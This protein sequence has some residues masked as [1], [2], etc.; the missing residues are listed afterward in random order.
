MV[1]DMY[2]ITNTALMTYMSAIITV[3]KQQ[4]Y[5]LKA[6]CTGVLTFHVVA[7]LVWQC[8]CW[9]A[10]T[11]TE[12]GHK[13][14]DG[15]QPHELH[16][17]ATSQHD[18]NARLLVDCVEGVDAMKPTQ[19]LLTRVHLRDISWLGMLFSGIKFGWG[20]LVFMYYN[21]FVYVMNGAG[22]MAP[23]LELESM[24]KFRK[25]FADEL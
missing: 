16:G 17:V 8:A 9:V 24:P 4:V 12:D 5:T 23:S 20:S 7:V 19:E 13:I 6:W 3:L 21:G 2:T 14:G 15:L 11:T 18:D 22:R 1:S 10:C 25:V